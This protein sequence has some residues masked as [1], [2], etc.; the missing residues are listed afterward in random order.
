MITLIQPWYVSTN[1]SRQKELEICLY[2]NLENEHISKVVL[3]CEHDCLIKHTKLVKVMINR[4]AMYNDMLNSRGIVVLANSDIYFNDT[5]AL[6]LSI[7]Q[8]ECYALSRWDYKG[9]KLVPFHGTDTQDVWIF[10][11]PNLTV[12]DYGMGMAGCDNRIAKEI[13]DAGYNITNPCL[14]I[15]AIHLHESGYRTYNPNN[16]VKGLYHYVLPCRL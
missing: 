8:N 2:N 12:G 10:N 14:S 3:Y 6:A 13:L 5:I 15:Q 4:R 9:G 7:K 1:P 11:N 16:P